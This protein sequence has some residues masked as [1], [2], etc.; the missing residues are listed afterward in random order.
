ME[1]FKDGRHPPPVQQDGPRQT[2]AR[3]AEKRRGRD[4]HH[5]LSYQF[6]FQA[7]LYPTTLCL[8]VPFSTRG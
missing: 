5:R 3:F 8:P 6:T 2:D 7:I 4:S 1:R